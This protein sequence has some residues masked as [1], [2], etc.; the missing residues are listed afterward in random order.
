MRIS[1][2]KL[3][4]TFG[5]VK[6]NSHPVAVTLHPEGRFLV[7]SALGGPGRELKPCQHSFMQSSLEHREEGEGFTQWSF[8]PQNIERSNLSL[9]ESG[10]LM[11][12]FRFAPPH[13]RFREAL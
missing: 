7:P 6:P 4:N 5:T 11:W 8:G 10:R 13:T 9:P 3:H 12:L 2:L 1:D